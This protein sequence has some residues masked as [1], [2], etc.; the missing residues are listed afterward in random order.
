MQRMGRR[1]T[2]D[3]DLPQRVYWHHGA[4]YF[5]DKAGKWHRLGDNK[6][7]ALRAYADMLHGPQSSFEALAKK[8]SETKLVHKAAKTRRDQTAQMQR[9]VDVFGKMPAAHIRPGH[10]AR[11]RDER[12]RTAPVAA[13]RELALLRHVMKTAVEWGIVPSN[14]CTGIS[15]NKEKARTRY[16]TDDEFRAVYEG[17]PMLV[18]VMMGLAYVTGQRESDLLRIRGSDLL[19]DGIAVTQG[20][21][22]KRL[23]IRWTDA[24]RA[25]VQLAI[26]MPRKSGIAS[27]YLVCRQ[28]GQPL[29]PDG[30]R[31]VWQR[32]IRACHESGLLAER[33]TF[34]DLRAKAGS[35]GTDEKLLGHMDPRVLNRVYRRRPEMVRPTR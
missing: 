33:F 16:V 8:Y 5:V 4:L 7:D 28:N 2:R 31:T 35:D 22:G 19:D 34:H 9:L 27:T 12:S 11:Y 15:G 25:A 6:A 21:T 29:T 1:R 26:D 24:L 30:F 14:P 10:V 32:H 18:Q 17:A 13:N 3:K 20:K 23:I